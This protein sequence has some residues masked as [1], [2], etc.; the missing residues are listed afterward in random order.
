MMGKNGHKEAR[1]SGLKAGQFKASHLQAFGYWLPRIPT[2]VSSNAPAISI[3]YNALVFAAS[4]CLF[5]LR[6]ALNQ[7]CKCCLTA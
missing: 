1:R 5:I 6:S 3:P 7:S 4:I 2:I